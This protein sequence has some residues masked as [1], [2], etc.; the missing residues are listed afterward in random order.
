MVEN[1]AIPETRDV[2]VLSFVESEALVHEDQNS[3]PASEAHPDCYE[4]GTAPRLAENQI[5]HSWKV[6]HLEPNL[7][8][9]YRWEFRYLHVSKGE[10]GNL[11]V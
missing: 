4:H 2:G 10:A 6:V 3:F 11:L 8:A 5:S 1:E 7:I 9:G